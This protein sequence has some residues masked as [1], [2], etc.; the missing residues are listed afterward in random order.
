METI[1]DRWIAALRSGEYPQILYNFRDNRGFCAIGVLYDIVDPANWQEDDDD[2]WSFPYGVYVLI[3]HGVSSSL[4]E[5][6]MNW[7]DDS[8]L[9]FQEIA[10]KLE[11][12]V[13]VNITDEQLSLLS[14]KHAQQITTGEV[15]TPECEAEA[16]RVGGQYKLLSDRSGWRIRSGRRAERV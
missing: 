5:R 9:S 2:I 1:I 13:W 11:E 15:I 14:D 12:G 4:V 10:D 16:I 7:N 8:H 3:R 6:V